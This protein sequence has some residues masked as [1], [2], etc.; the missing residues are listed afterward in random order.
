MSNLRENFI[1]N[2]FL[3]GNSQDCQISCLLF[4]FW[5]C[6]K[7]VFSDSGNILICLFHVLFITIRSKAL[8]RGNIYITHFGPEV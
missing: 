6:V 8:T 4:A 1:S 7:A 3:K 5:L 2:A